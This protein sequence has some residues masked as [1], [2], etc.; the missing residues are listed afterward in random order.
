M[1]TNSSF[2]VLNF[3]ILDSASQIHHNPKHLSF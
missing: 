1:T 2:L 3:L